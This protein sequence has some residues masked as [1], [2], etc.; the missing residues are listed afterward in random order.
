MGRHY[1][2][3]ADAR[4]NTKAGLD[5]RISMRRAIR[6]QMGNSDGASLHDWIGLTPTFQPP[7]PRAVLGCSAEKAEGPALRQALSGI[8][9]H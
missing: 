1:E 6:R 9:H 4:A 5:R 3:A 2:K 7:A 8:D